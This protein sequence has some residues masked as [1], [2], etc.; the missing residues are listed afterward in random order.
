MA[1]RDRILE[2]R[3][4]LDGANYAYYVDADPMMPD[5][6]Y[7]ELLRELVQLEEANPEYQC[8]RLITHTP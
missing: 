3:K 8:N 1:P 6:Q 7:D 4:L 2:L 5:S